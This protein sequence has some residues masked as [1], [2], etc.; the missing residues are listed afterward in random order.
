MKWY[1]VVLGATPNC[2]G[3]PACSYGALI[4][5]ARPLKDLNFYSISEQKAALVSLHHNVKGSFY[6]PR[7]GA[8]CS[9][10][11]VVWAEGKFRYIIGLKAGSQRDVIR[12]ANSAID[13]ANP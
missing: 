1:I 8:Y 9:D 3:Q 13:A 11:V 10:S 12:A 7:C 2:E 5:T 4:G 6:A